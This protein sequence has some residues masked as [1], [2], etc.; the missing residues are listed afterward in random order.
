[1][2]ECMK[3]LEFKSPS[4][5]QMIATLETDEEN[6]NQVANVFNVTD[7]DFICTVI[8]NQQQGFAVI[9]KGAIGIS[10]ESLE[11]VREFMKEAQ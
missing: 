10:F 5:N 1:M 2:G 8:H 9:T 4:G 3:T 7:R 11:I 6:G